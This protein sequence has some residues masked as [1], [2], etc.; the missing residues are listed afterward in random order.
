MPPE[1][2]KTDRKLVEEQLELILAS[3]VFR[4]AARS[5]AFLRYVVEHSLDDA[6]PKEY[7][8]ATEVLG[9]SSDY[10]PAVDATVR[11]EAGRLR[12][13]LREYYDTEGIDDPVAIEIPKGGYAAV[14]TLRPG[15]ASGQ[16]GTPG[17]E[18]RHAPEAAGSIEV[19]QVSISPQAEQPQPVPGRR[20]GTIEVAAPSFVQD[21]A[22]RAKR[23]LLFR[24]R[25][26]V[27]GLAAFAPLAL[28]TFLLVVHARNDARPVSKAPIRMAVLP[29]ANETGIPANGPLAEGLT[30]NLIRQCSEIS[31]LRVMSRAAVDDVTRSSA[32][33][34]LGA[35][36]LLTG[37]L[38]EN[39]DGELTVDAELSATRDGSVL[40]SRRYIA[41]HGDLQSVQAEIV[42]DVI[43]GLGIELDARSSTRDKRPS[44]TSPA[45]LQ[46]FL[47]GEAA[48]RDVSPHSSHMAIASFN[49]AARKDPNFARAWTG[50]ADS[51]AY[52]GM[53]FEPATEHMPLAREYA[54]RALS[55]DP[56]LPEAHGIL[57]LVY[58]IY[59]WNPA[60]AQREL[61]TMGARKVSITRL[62]C[63]AHLL[64]Q[65]GQLRHADEDIHAMLEFDPHSPSLID[66]LG[67][68]HY[69]ARD[70][71]EAIRYSRQGLAESFRKTG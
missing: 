61:A 20:G 56:T 25:R 23:A 11:V 48:Q 60:A 18:T 38:R 6:P 13:R 64:G 57:G 3:R 7:S 8:I 32:G 24:H 58:L 54:A 21:G 46:D 34:R 43:D 41:E 67:C 47:R 36:A 30:Q 16:A 14:F 71:E 59:G 49:A 12:N 33:S 44:T 39:A 51:H 65:T 53:Y 62:A 66:E 9:R 27:G 4:L 1:R 31:P 50:L 55:L 70:F 68:I 2:T 37:T 29:F 26:L 10:D 5:R 40:R 35:A 17:R 19:I 45:A 42:E 15:A 69:Y 63:T 52:L 22:G 28:L